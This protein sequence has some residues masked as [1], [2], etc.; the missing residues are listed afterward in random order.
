VKKILFVFGTRPE[1][2]KMAPLVREFQQHPDQFQVLV[3]VTA[4]HRH[5]LDQVLAFFSIRP[6]YDLNLM[7]P[8]QTLFDI[9]ANGLKALESVLKEANPDLIFVQGDT[10]TAFIGALAAYY[11]KI[12]VAH[13][14]AGLRSSNKYSPFPEEANRTMVGHLADYHFAPTPQAQANLQREGISRNIHIV[15][16]TVIDALLLGLDILK[17]EGDQSYQ[18]HFRAIDFSKKIILVT[19]HR[20]ESFGE[21]FENICLA[22]RDLA[23][24]FPE[25]EIVY[26]VHLNPNVQETVRRVLHNLTNV[27]LIDPLD[28][29]YLIWLMNRCYLVL[30][31][32]GGI[33]EE[34]PSLGKPVVVMRDVTERQEGIDAGT[35]VL[36]GTD[37]QKIYHT[38]SSLL[39]DPAHY[40]RMAQAV[41]PYGDGTTSRQIVNCLRAELTD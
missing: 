31:D 16:N 5:M 38:V 18:N 12:P 17:E 22:I 11:L 1:A 33:Q 15:G 40:H 29:P 19:G 9:T 25:V 36:V 7:Q 3:C 41:N 20:R 34:A 39:T 13:L 14:E 2:I 30:T 26:P 21:P 37:R 4:Q 23:Q 8:N 6:D 35:A 32:S 27:Y 24:T 28:Y 10:T